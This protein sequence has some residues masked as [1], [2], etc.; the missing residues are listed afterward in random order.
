[1]WVI[2]EPCRT[3]D[4]HGEVLVDV[5]LARLFRAIVYLTH[6]EKAFKVGE[7]EVTPEM[8]KAGGDALDGIIDDESE[9][10]IQCVAKSVFERMIIAAKAS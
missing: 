6:P 9:S 1:L 5:H 4:L 3:G 2:D 8:L 10:Y 7:I